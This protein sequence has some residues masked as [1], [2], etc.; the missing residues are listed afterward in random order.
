MTTARELIDA[1]LNEMH[2]AKGSE[3]PA[4][5]SVINTLKKLYDQ[6]KLTKAQYDKAVKD[7]LNTYKGK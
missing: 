4:V 1:R 3:D 2:E 7:F 5:Q 6:G